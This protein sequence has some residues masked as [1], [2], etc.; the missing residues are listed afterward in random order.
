MS[1]LNERLRQAIDTGNELGYSLSRPDLG[2]YCGVS[3]TALMHWFNGTT[4][5][6]DGENLI[7]AADYLRVSARWLETGKGEMRPEVDDYPPPNLPPGT[8]WHPVIAWETPDDLPPD[9]Y[10]IIPR[11]NVKFSAGAGQIAFEVEQKEQGLAFLWKWIKSKGLNPKNL[12]SIYVKGD[13]MYP[14]IPDGS[15]VVIDTSKKELIGTRKVYAIRYGD[16]LKIKRLSKRFDGA[17]VI[18]SD[19]PAYRPEV[20]EGE[21]LAHVEI[22]GKYVMHS[23]DGEL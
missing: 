21:S 4:K 5:G 20:V 9:E 23:F 13:S 14:A 8:R 18:E 12:M 22:V 17:W 7:K 10:V 19:N 3:K 16:E 1:L 2:R 6:L 11:V 15:I